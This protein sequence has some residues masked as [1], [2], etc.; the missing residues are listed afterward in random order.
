[1]NF[2][3]VCPYVRYANIVPTVMDGISER[4]AADCRLFYFLQSGILYAGNI[5]YSVIPG[6][7]VYIPAGIAYNIVGAPKAAV[8]NFD[9]SLAAYSVPSK[10]PYK[11]AEFNPDYIFDK[12]AP[13]KELAN[14]IFLK[15]ALNLEKQFKTC[16][17]QTDINNEITASL[18]S[19]FTKEILSEMASARNEDE[20]EIKL[21][22]YI[23][24]N[25]DR[26]L[27]N[28]ELSEVFGYHP[29]HLNRIFKAR[30]GT[31]VHQA[32]INERMDISHRL[33]A[34]TDLSVNEISDIVGY[35]DR[36]AFYYAFKKNTGMSPVE[37]RAEKQA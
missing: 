14:V 35:K 11:A 32:L 10:S 37:F 13:P 20:I 2:I 16:T 19:A 22:L 9:L 7:A 3:S 15:Q 8:L 29:Y 23:K 26:D 17:I 21:M 18:L 4:K 6:S 36:I 27:S 5:K 12:T 31:T 30:F 28:T 25:Y 24:E 1:M 33:L 34:D